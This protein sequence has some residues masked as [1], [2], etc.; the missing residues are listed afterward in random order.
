MSH[1]P[2]STYDNDTSRFD[3]N[4]E[5][6][7]L[8]AKRGLASWLVTVDHKRLGVMYGVAV[9]FF[10]M[11]AGLLAIL[12]RTELFTPDQDIMSAQTYNQ[13][14]TLHGAIMVFLFIIPSVPAALGNFLL[15]LM[16]GAKD[17]AF[18]KLNLL[19]FYLYSVASV[20]FIAAMSERRPRHRLD[21]LHA[22]LDLVGH[23]GHRG[24]RRR[25]HRSASRRSS[26]A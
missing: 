5:P 1:A 9:M 21:V 12:L 10:F 19:S 7:Y 17:V 24:D 4:L 26:P 23:G 22:V 14:F 20:F 16:L 13:V 6:S 3:K 18:P 15:P 25:L 11:I 8:V 2:V